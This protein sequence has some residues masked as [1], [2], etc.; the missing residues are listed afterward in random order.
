MHE[1]H[2]KVES[3]GFLQTLCENDPTTALAVAQMTLDALKRLFN[4]VG[5][6]EL[7]ANRPHALFRS[8]HL[9]CAPPRERWLRDRP[10]P[11]KLA[12]QTL[13]IA[14]SKSR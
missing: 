7:M 2:A 13:R 14:R 9:V 6:I 12:V 10:L 5:E 3:V 8:L 4:V 1:I 11:E